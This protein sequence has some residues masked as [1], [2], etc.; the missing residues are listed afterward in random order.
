MTSLL[1]AAAAA[2]LTLTAFNAH[3]DNYL[4]QTD[5]LIVK[6]KDAVPAGKGGA[7]VASVS[8]LRQGMVDRAGQQL[9]TR[10]T[11]LRSVSTGAHLFQLSRSVPL[12]EASALAADLMARDPSVEYAEPDRI[13]TTQVAATDPRYTEQWDLYDLTGGIRMPGAWNF[14][15][16]SGINVAVI[17][18]GYRPH[19]DLAGQVLPGYDFIAST[20]TAGDGNARDADATD[21]GDWLT[22][23]QCS[24]GMPMA[25]QSSSWHGTHVAGT[26]AAKANNG[27]GVAGI[28]YNAK[29]VP[30]RVLGK[31]GGY[32]S[33]IADGIIWASGGTVA[34]VAANPNKARVLNLSLGGGGACDVTTQTAI[35][36]ARS[37]GAVVVV[38]AGNSAMDASS[39]T[40][41]SCAGVIAV[42]AT[43]HSGGRSSY[44]N[45]GANVD[46]AAPGD[47]ILSTVNTG[48][49]APVAD[50]YASYSGTSMATPHVAGVAALM[51][52]QNPSLTPDQVETKLK[53]SARWFPAP[54]SG[55][56]T[57]IL[58]ANAALNGSVATPPATPQAEAEPNDTI[59]T[60]NL[61]ATAGTLVNATIGSTSDADYFLVQLPAGKQLSVTMAPGT[62]EADYDLYLYNAAGAVLSRSENGSGAMESVSVRNKSTATVAYYIGVRY[63]SGGTG[64]TAGKY[65]VQAIW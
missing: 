48:T 42:A 25:D 17:D 47:G 58:D 38:A 50:G 7:R 54:C 16:G 62:S 3:A 1:F 61:I 64:A 9:G 52:A 13:L 28:A 37:R 45:Y 30:V 41:A 35:N 15:T 24:A 27:V 59:V 43:N 32:T 20:A 2:A 44:S 22:A 33:D 6:Y 40:P 10:L 19:A 46:I 39:F 21:P 14:S 12:A 26:I 53:A 4:T 5:R 51:L 31:C 23:S 11:L 57:G 8:A 18:T 60:A 29:I 36:G 63:Y 55:C 49:R 65:T 34:G 56:G